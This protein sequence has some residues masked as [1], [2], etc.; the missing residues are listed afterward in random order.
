MS[1]ENQKR[2]IDRIHHAR[3]KEK[4][5]LKYEQKKLEKLAEDESIV[6]DESKK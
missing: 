6:E 3:K 4:T 2:E 5:R 1:V